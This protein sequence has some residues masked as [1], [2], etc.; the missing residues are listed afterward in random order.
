MR[1]CEEDLEQ[2]EASKF[3]R[4]LG[5]NATPEFLPL[6]ETQENWA[7]FL[8]LVKVFFFFFS[9][10]M[11]EICMDNPIKRSKMPNDSYLKEMSIDFQ[12]TSWV[13]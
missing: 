8:Q 4:N 3:L 12:L 7:G 10:T 6:V 1:F 5:A 2:D 9:V 11:G 13:Y